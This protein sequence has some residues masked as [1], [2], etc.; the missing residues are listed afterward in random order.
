MNTWG[1]QHVVA[2]GDA[3]AVDK[4]TVEVDAYVGAYVY[5]R[6]E[7]ACEAVAHTYIRTHSAEQL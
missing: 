6:T 2:N 4:R 3:V 7:T 5:V 1:N